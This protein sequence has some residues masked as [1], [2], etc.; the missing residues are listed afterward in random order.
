MTP[1]NLDRDEPQSAH[2]GS[3]GGQTQDEEWS[4]RLIQTL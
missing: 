2:L 1:S 4:S 3:I